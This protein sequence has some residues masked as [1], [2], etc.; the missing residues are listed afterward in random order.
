M[1]VELHEKIPSAPAL[2]QENKHKGE[3]QIGYIFS[4]LGEIL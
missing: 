4:K 2:H 1:L 3:E